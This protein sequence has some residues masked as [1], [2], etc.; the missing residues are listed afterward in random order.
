[1]LID[2]GGG[3]YVSVNGVFEYNPSHVPFYTINDII[4]FNNP[5]HN[6]ET[7]FYVCIKN[8]QGNVSIYDPNYFV[9][10]WYYN[11]INNFQD[12]INSIATNDL[13][14]PVTKKVLEAVQQYKFGT[15]YLIADASSFEGILDLNAVR[16]NGRYVIV[17]EKIHDVINFPGF[18]LSEVS[19]GYVSRVFGLDVYGSEDNLVQVIFSNV[20]GKILVAVRDG[21]LNS[22]ENFIWNDWVVMRNSINIAALNNY[23]NSVDNI[24][25]SYFNT[26]SKQSYGVLI[27]YEINEDGNLH[28][29]LSSVN[30]SIFKTLKSIMIN[31]LLESGSSR[32]VY[33][34]MLPV[35]TVSHGSYK[36]FFFS[37]LIET[38]FSSDE[39]IVLINQITSDPST[40]IHNIEIYEVIG[41]T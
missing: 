22:S 39:V 35:P 24:R 37:K 11:I 12:V 21:Y 1:M 30:R 5:D 23:L 38:T 8:P 28:I 26:I 41:F 13:D 40:G 27:N 20:G 16:R 19:S 15:G 31:C 33:N 6:N 25:S 7:E 3:S 34:H 36:T 4:Y 18:I 2:V 29:K 14:R 32:I 9:P 17:L 10:I